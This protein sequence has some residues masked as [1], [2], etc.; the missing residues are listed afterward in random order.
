MFT[1]IEAM[2]REEK[3]AERDQLADLLAQHRGITREEVLEKLF[4]APK[5]GPPIRREVTTKHMQRRVM[6]KNFEQGKLD[7]Q[8]CEEDMALR[9]GTSAYWR[10]VTDYFSRC[11]SASPG[12]EHVIAPGLFALGRRGWGWMGRNDAAWA[13]M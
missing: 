4:D 7:G 11:C 6:Q 9:K 3:I 8:I 5:I 2:T 10:A 13:T 12:Y 1:P